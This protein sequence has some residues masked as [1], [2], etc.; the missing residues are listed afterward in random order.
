MRNKLRA[1]TKKKTNLDRKE[2]VTESGSVIK[3]SFSFSKINQLMLA[4]QYDLK[5]Y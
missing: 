3:N 2:F 1:L 5:I 4:V